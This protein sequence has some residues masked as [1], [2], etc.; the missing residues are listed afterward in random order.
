MVKLC[1]AL[2]LPI[3]RPSTSSAP[4]IISSRTQPFMKGRFYWSKKAPRSRLP[5]LLLLGHP[6]RRSVQ[7]PERRATASP[8]ATVLPA[9]RSP[10]ENIPS[11]GPLHWNS[12]RAYPGAFRLGG[13]GCGMVDAKEELRYHSGGWT[14]NSSDGQRIAGRIGST[15][16]PRQPALL[17]TNNYKYCLII[18]CRVTIKI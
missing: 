15:P 5:Q 11:P 18:A 16:S 13:A 7:L 14:S 17:L 10:S 6:R 8:T 12:S 1:G 2:P 3:I 9:E 4:G